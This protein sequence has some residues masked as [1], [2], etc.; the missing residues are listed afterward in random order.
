MKQ[1]SILKRQSGFLK[2]R[3]TP[4]KLF[5]NTHWK[6]SAELN[7]FFQPNFELILEKENGIESSESLKEFLWQIFNHDR[8]KRIKENYGKFYFYSLIY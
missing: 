5:S 6:D 7:S 8:I 1:L 4:Q 2:L 3:K